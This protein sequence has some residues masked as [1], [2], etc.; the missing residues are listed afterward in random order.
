MRVREREDIG[1]LTEE[2]PTKEWNGI[3]RKF[4]ESFAHK[5]IFQLQT[6]LLVP[7]FSIIPTL[8]SL[9]SHVSRA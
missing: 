9:P 3:V 1:R 8:S 2:N 5:S 6:R 7:F 4:G